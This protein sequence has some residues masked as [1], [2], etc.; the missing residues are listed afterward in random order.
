MFQPGLT[1][2]EQEPQAGEVV[3]QLP[4]SLPE[5]TNVPELSLDTETTGV[6]PFTAKPVGISIAY[7]ADIGMKKCYFP[8]GHASGNLDPDLVRRWGNHELKGKTIVFANGKYDIHVLKAWGLDLEAIGVQPCDI[9][10]AAALL[11]DSPHVRVDLDTLGRQYA[12]VA[13]ADFP[14]DK[15]KMAELPSWMVGNYAETD[16][17]N[18]L[19]V[20]QATKPFIKRDG[21]EAVLALENSIIYAVC[22]IERNGCRIDVVKLEVWRHE[23]R[24]L[25]E[26]TLMDLY[27]MTG[28]RVEPDSALSMGLLL[29]HLK[30]SPPAPQPKKGRKV[31]EAKNFDELAEE[32]NIPGQRKFTE[33]ELLSL[34]HPVL[35]KVVEARWYS[36][37]L[38]KFLD[39]YSQ[40]VESGK[41]RSQF[42]QL[43]TEAVEKGKGRGTISGRFSSSG[44]GKEDNG[45]SFNAQQVIRPSLQRD[46]AG[47][48]HIIRELFIPEQGMEYFSADLSQIEYRIAAHFANA[49]R[50]I[51]A[52]NNDPKTDFHGI[53]QGW[54]QVYKPQHH[55]RTITKNVNFAFVFGSGEKTLAATANISEVESG[56]LLAILRSNAPEFPQLL[57][58]LA[59]EAETRGYVTTITGRRARFG[60]EKRFYAALNRVVQGSA[61][62]IFKIYLR[63]IYNERHTLGITSLRQ[64]VHDEVNGDKLPG[65]LYTNRIQE[66][67]NEQKVKLKVPITWDLRTGKNWS[68][69]H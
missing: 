3:W 30:I 19:L 50:M 33:E 28:M 53:T 54:I 18:T 59:R 44:G 34:K 52:Y 1:F 32:M 66:F 2:G 62:D 61:A 56:E 16:A 11:D 23:V 48:H 22:E 14:H 24:A 21:L 26:Q 60:T 38:S 15:D 51:D 13:K 8:F 67:M 4:D 57:K 40:G 47:D 35:N 64:V 69:C 39:K 43:K 20:H 17:E 46:T 37:L 41:I 65:D 58:N 63:A 27:N 31:K 45:Y 29:S 68:E 25:Y 7:P 9:Q 42:H 36:S 55:D 49:K 5:L 6:N 10:F 12:G